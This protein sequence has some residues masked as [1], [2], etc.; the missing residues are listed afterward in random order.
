MLGTCILMGWEKG[1]WG[2]LHGSFMQAGSGVSWQPGSSVHWN[3]KSSKAYVWIKAGGG[4]FLFC[5]TDPVGERER[6]LRSGGP[7]GPG[8]LAFG[9]EERGA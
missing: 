1:L 8:C 6:E 9:W 5:F 2:V 7:Q 3:W 4:F